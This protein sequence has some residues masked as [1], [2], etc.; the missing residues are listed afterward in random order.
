LV[1]LRGNSTAQPD[2]SAASLSRKSWG[3]LRSLIVGSVETFLG[4]GLIAQ[5]L[6]GVTHIAEGSGL[7]A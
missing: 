5:C 1:H 3:L 4:F 6:I 2:K 7:Q